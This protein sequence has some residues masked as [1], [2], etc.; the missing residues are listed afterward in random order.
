MS[1]S[2]I[3]S[4]MAADGLFSRTAGEIVNGASKD[5]AV[6]TRLVERG[7]EGLTDAIA[8]EVDVRERN[9][10]MSCLSL[11][12]G[13]VRWSCIRVSHL[14]R[15]RVSLRTQY[16]RERSSHAEGSDMCCGARD[17]DT[18]ARWCGNR[19]PGRST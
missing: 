15:W 8:Y 7:V 10:H 2:P 1:F 19:L 3:A 5:D 16:E 12:F 13:R 14:A 11:I 6:S 17:D 18:D 9:Y 4:F